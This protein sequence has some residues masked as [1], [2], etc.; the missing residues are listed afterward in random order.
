MEFLKHKLG[1][2]IDCY[3]KH[4]KPLSSIERSN[5]KGIYPYYGAQE[6]ID[7]IQQY[8]FDGKYILL[9]EDGENLRSRVKPIANIVEGKFWLNNHA[10]IFKTKKGF[11]MEYLCYYLNSIDISGY[12]T[13]TTQPKLNQTNMKNIELYLPTFK[14]QNKIAK[15]INA[16]NNKISENTTTNDN[17]YEIGITTINYIISNADSTITLNKIIKFIKGK[18]PI[19]IVDTKKENYLKYLTIACLNNQELNYADSSKTII[20][21]NDLL[22]VM[23]GA[24]SGDIYYSNYGIVGS[25]LAKIEILDD[26]FQKEYVF[27]LI[28]NYNDLIKSKNTGSAIPHTDKVFVGTLEVPNISKDKQEY[29]VTLLKKINQNSKENETLVKLRDTLLPKLMNGEIELDNIKI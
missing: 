25:T 3:D 19:E 26:E 18:K 28:K 27:F 24:S 9:A 21:N 16:I 12:I 11:N 23:D 15:I 13:G 29:F 1:N 10:H 2:I 20:C 5:F 8:I 6:I 4:R 14:I 22:M 17:L 7:N